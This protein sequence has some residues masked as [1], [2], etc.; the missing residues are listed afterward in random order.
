[1][2]LVDTGRAKPADEKYAIGPYNLTRSQINQMINGGGLRRQTFTY[3]LE[4]TTAVATA[5]TDGDNL[6]ELGAID[7]LDLL[8]DQVGDYAP[9]KILIKSAYIN[10]QTIAGQAL[11]AHLRI[12]ATSGTLTNVALTSGTEVVG[13]GATY[14]NETGGNLT[15]TETD[16]DLQVAALLVHKP[17]ISFAIAKKYLY[18]CTT[19]AINA[20]ITAGRGTVT[21]EYVV[22]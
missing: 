5:Y 16:L 3:S 12:S 1:M 21:I 10:V 14:I 7:V 18:L 13:A 9:T 19:T 11:S 8:S 6:V 4:D 22:I 17:G 2:T 20:D 15:L